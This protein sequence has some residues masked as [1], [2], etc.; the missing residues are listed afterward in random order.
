MLE[1]VEQDTWNK[2]NGVCKVKS[3]P[4]HEYGTTQESEEDSKIEY[5]Y[6]FD[7]HLPNLEDEIH[8]KGC[9][10]VTS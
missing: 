5:A 1:L 10:I 7:H 2:V 8:L 4:Y 3:N 6:L 9:R